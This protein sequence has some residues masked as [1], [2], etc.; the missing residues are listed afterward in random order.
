MPRTTQGLVY[1]G[2]MIHYEVASNL[3]L[4]TEP[5]P[6]TKTAK[7]EPQ[8]TNHILIIDCSGSMYG[9]LPKIR[10]Q[11]KA[12]LP[13]LLA[14]G[15]TISLIW[16]S[17]RGEFGTLVKGEPVADLKDLNDLNK[18]IDRW[19]KP[20]GLTG[21]KEPLVEA[22]KLVEEL[23]GVCS[24]FFMSD[25]YDNQWR[26][27]EILKAVQEL[28]PLCA[29]TTFV[30]YGHYCNHPLLV[31]MAETAGGQLIFNEDFRKYEPTV[32]AAL[33][34][35]ALGAK[36]VTLDL[37]GDPIRG[38]AFAFDGDSL[39]TFKVEGGSVKVPEHLQEVYYLSPSAV[40]KAEKKAP[41]KAVY[42]ATALYAQRMDSTV[43]LSLLKNT[44]DVRF[45]KLFGGCFGK[46][47]YAEFV[48]ATTQAAIDPSLRLTKG[49]DPSAIPDDDAFTVLDL[50]RI[51]ADDGDNRL[52]LESNDFV[53]SRI[54]RGR[55]QETT[56]TAEQQTQ[57]DELEDQKLGASAAEVKKLQKKIDAI[58]EVAQPLA[59]KADPI[60]H[61]VTI[62]NLV[63][64]ETRPN[65]SVQVRR[66]GTVNIKHRKPKG[67]Y[68]KVP[69]EFP[70][71]IF[72]NYTIIRDGVI[73]VEKLPLRVT[74]ETVTRLLDAGM[75]WEAIQNLGTETLEQTQ[76]RIKKASKDR[77]VD[78]VVNLTTLPV[79]NRNMIKE[80]SAQEFFELDYELSQWRAAQKVYNTLLKENFQGK[81]SEG[82][83][84]LYGDEATEWLKGLG[85]TDYSGFNPGG[86]V[87][88]ARDWYVGKELHVLIKGLSNIPSLNDYNKRVASGKGLTAAQALLKPA[89][90]AVEAF[91]ASDVYKT[92]KD[93][94]KVFQAWL[95]SEQQAAKTRVR[96]L[97]YKVSQIRFG[98]IVGQVWF[99]EFSS[100]E[101]NTLT[102][103]VGGNDLTGTVT[104]KE[105]EVPV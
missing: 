63:F 88:E 77:E 13:A 21:F 8:P 102:F 99:K 69:D 61:G 82:F 5:L 53:Y 91:Q 78:L 100:L 39:L 3:F 57:I 33:Q 94:P 27:D 80:V 16:F 87:A 52:L 95:Q 56:L 37:P 68:K 42:A 1:L 6:S 67:E 98:V 103:K 14:K 12:K 71:F 10:N 46:Q 93:Q 50:L 29:S 65:V 35:R 75:P 40:G 32:E 24:I 25:G 62:D 9:D 86:K 66:E 51:L 101:E 7:P 26:S 96:K 79:I 18:A 85:F 36:R 60:P 76:T 83:K 15:D 58:I 38:F 28:A 19:L 72:R 17:S 84:V 73:N 44:G 31:Q 105:I 90:D 81:K 70:T 59:F 49:C 4:V 74:K 54:G 20:V 48:E 2:D 23:G 92:S 89:V 22:K 43:V 104:M 11:L 30:E 45:I 34:K 97:L 64:N 55:V 47:K 41:E